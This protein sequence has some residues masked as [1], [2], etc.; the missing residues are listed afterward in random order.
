MWGWES[1]FESL[2]NGKKKGSGLEGWGVMKDS[3]R[4]SGTL[5]GDREKVK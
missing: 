1:D 4:E 3:R 5:C 2:K